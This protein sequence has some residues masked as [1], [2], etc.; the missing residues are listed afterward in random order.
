MT[1]AEFMPSAVAA[2]IYFVLTY[3]GTL[4]YMAGLTGQGGVNLVL[5]HT[6]AYFAVHYLVQKYYLNKKA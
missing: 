1:S 2:A 3:P 6:V 5:V 4:N